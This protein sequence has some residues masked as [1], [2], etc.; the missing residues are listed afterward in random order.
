MTEFKKYNGTNKVEMRPYI[1]GETL[2][3][4]VSI[5][6]KDLENGS[7]KVGDIIV[8]YPHSHKDTWLITR[9]YFENNFEKLNQ[10]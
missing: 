6:K 1:E 5:S 4:Y 9:E 2:P 7:P 8:R 3:D 10:E